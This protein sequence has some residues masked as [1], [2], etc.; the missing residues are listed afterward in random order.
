MGERVERQNLPLTIT[1]RGLEALG[2]APAIK[3]SL[4]PPEEEKEASSV[5][6]D[7]HTQVD[8]RA[9]ER[10][11]GAVKRIIRRRSADDCEERI[12]E[13]HIFLGGKE[14]V[15]RKKKS[16]T[17]LCVCVCVVQTCAHARASVLNT[18]SYLLLVWDYQRWLSPTSLI[19]F[20]D[21]SL[22]YEGSCFI[23]VLCCSR[24]W[25]SCM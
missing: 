16:R 21:M 3:R 11:G 18:A 4:P 13:K 9:E 2:Y 10:R 15:F 12:K 22:F 5:L 24:C 14:K 6:I 23:L 17:C 25:I 19:W 7:T 20:R 1:P 8:R